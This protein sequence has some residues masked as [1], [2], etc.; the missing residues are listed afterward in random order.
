MLIENRNRLR[1]EITVPGDKSISHRAIVIGALASGTTEI[2]NF[3]LGEDCISTIDCFRRMQVGIEIL[4]NNRV[5]VNGRGLYG[6]KAPS[7]VLNSGRSGTALRLLL[8]VLC[9]QPFTSGVIRN[10]FSMKKPVGKVVHYLRRMGANI[11]GREDGNLCPLTISPSRL[12]GTECVLPI[13]EMHIKSPLLLAGLYSEGETTVNEPVRSRNHTELMLNYFGADIREE[14][15]CVKSHSVENLY[16]QKVSIPGDISMAAYFITAALLVPNSDIVIKD[17]GVNPTRI[18]I[19]NVYKQM[20]AKIELLNE[21]T[22]SGERV[23]DIHVMTSGLKSAKI[24]QQLVPSLID[25]LPVIIVAAALAEGTTEITG[26]SG[27]KVKQSGKL[28]AISMELA[29]MGAKIVENEDGLVIEGRKSLRGTVVDSNNNH[30]HAMALSIAGLV[31]EE[32]TTIRK[33]HSV[34][35]VYPTFYETLNKL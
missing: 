4:Q 11:S 26:L 16:A 19:L 13:H 27:F 6:L 20:G 33:T 22:V 2:D 24:N 5:R 17:V 29:K 15:H 23:A 12:K 9:G 3:L 35:I 32:E 31:A 21:R 30:S 7:S 8:G 14:G 28:K 34:D 25:E 18:G 1:G 10:E